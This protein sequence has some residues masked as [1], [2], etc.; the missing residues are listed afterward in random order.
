MTCSPKTHLSEFLTKLGL[1]AGPSLPQPVFALFNCTP[2]HAGCLLFSHLS[3]W[4]LV[5]HLAFSGLC[6][7]KVGWADLG[8]EKPAEARPLSPSTHVWTAWERP[9]SGAGQGPFMQ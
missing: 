4:S 3:P 8:S 5:S 7:K 9:D 1:K 2:L 6:E